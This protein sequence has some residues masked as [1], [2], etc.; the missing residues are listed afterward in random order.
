MNCF[1]KSIFVLILQINIF[2]IV[3]AQN[4]DSIKFI[5]YRE[6]IMLKV[7][8]DTQTEEFVIA[9]GDDI[10]RLALNNKTK[11]SLSLDYK[12]ISASVSFSPKFLPGNND[13]DSKGKSS[14]TDLKFRFFPGKFIQTF[15][16]KRM[17]GFYLKNMR[18]FAPGWQEENHPYVQFPALKNT[19]FGGSTSFVFNPE[20]SLKS[21][22]YQRE[23]Q[24][25]STGSFV[26][27]LNYDLSFLTNDFETY[28]GKERELDFNFDLAYYY[29]WVIAEK[30]TVA[31][32]AYAGAGI[33]FTKYREQGAEINSVEKDKYFTYE[34]GTGI[35][36][37]F[38]SEKFLF[39]GRLNYSSFNYKPDDERFSNNSLY[40]LIFVGYRFNPPKKVERIY[41]KIEQKNPF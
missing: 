3:Y 12:I 39:G 5:S 20:F 17:K 25:Y 8:L 9:D 33:R 34:Y 10:Y 19:V 35:H 29:N 38:N 26:P 11:L 2:S 18:D 7:N 31:P 36:L 24:K 30:F 28:T 14:F 32:Y 27:S 41:E 21:L 16:Y 6:K 22:L 4:S 15:H 13:D 1:Y 37:G 23:W 40:G